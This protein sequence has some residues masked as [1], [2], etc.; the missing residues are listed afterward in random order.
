MD[1]LTGPTL[2]ALRKRRYR[3]RLREGEVVVALEIGVDALE[4]LTR[5]GYL[6][7]DKDDR[8]SIQR[9]VALA[10]AEALGN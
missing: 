4:E 5:R 7:F 2:A 1:Q 10:L 6:A 3:A 9:A 8:D